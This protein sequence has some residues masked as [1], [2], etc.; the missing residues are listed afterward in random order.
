M[1]SDAAALRSSALALHAERNALEGR[2]L[3][4]LEALGPLA[5]GPLVDAEGFPVSGVD[6]YAVAAQRQEVARLRTDVAKKSQELEAALLSVHAAAA[7][8]GGGGGGGGAAGS[9]AAVGSE[10]TGGTAGAVA[11]GADGGGGAASAPASC[12]AVLGEVTAGGPAAEG[13]LQ[14]GDYVVA[15]D[16]LAAGGGGGGS[17]AGLHDLAL[18]ARACAQQGRPLRLKV[19]RAGAE[20]ALEVRP[21]AWAGEGILGCRLLAVAGKL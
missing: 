21:G 16:G 10:A 3:A 18:S 19:L 8:R 12:L 5:S 15:W 17:P 9:A 1:A 14:P 11:I 4:L 7:P 13:G 6:L 20:R 2:L